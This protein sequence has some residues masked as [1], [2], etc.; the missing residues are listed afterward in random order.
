MGKNIN[1]GMVVLV[2]ILSLG[3][4]IF[5]NLYIDN[6]VRSKAK[7]NFELWN[8]IIFLNGT[9]LKIQFN[10]DDDMWITI[11]NQVYNL[12]DIY[13]SSDYM[14]GE[15]I[16]GNKIMIREYLNDLNYLLNVNDTITIYNTARTKINDR[17]IF[18]MTYTDLRNFE[19]SLISSLVVLFLGLLFILCILS[20]VVGT[21]IFYMKDKKY[22]K[23]KMKKYKRIWEKHELQL[24]I[25]VKEYNELQRSYNDLERKTKKFNVTFDDIR[26]VKRQ[27]CHECG[28]EI[29]SSGN[30]VYCGAEVRKL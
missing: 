12:G 19:F 17:E 2:F 8:E 27:Y 4:I 13:R 24:N 14:S 3:G 7:I 1:Y 28:S 23:E 21:K 10:L 5:G 9:V 15:N 18:S 22:Y 16:R 11:E 29:L 20:V 25:R 6:S 26:S 30:C